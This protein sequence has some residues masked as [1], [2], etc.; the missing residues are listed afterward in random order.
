MNP[1][2]K[3]Q[4]G[5]L[6]RVGENGQVERCRNAYFYDDQVVGG[7]A[8][9]VGQVLAY[10]PPLLTGLLENQV[11]T[12]ERPDTGQSQRQLLHININKDT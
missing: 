1:A 12:R 8:E 9:D 7:G 4:T 3:G 11:V 5:V 10:S 2:L 6:G